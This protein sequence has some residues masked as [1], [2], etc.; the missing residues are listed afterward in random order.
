MQTMPNSCSS[1]ARRGR[2]RSVARVA[3]HRQIVRS[4]SA[5]IL[6]TRR[7]PVPAQ[8]RAHVRAMVRARSAP[9]CGPPSTT[10]LV[11]TT[12]PLACGSIAATLVE[13]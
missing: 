9:V 2:L 1:I 5:W 13:G 10:G 7:A 6:L 8:V 4:P 3:R 12:P 11:P